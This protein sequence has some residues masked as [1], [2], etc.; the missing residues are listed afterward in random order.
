MKADIATYVS[1]CLTCAKV[2]A[3]HQKP[4]GLLVQPE[5]PEWKRDNITMDFVT[6]LPKSSQGYDTIWVIVDRLTKSAIFTP[7]RET[8]PMDK[9]AR[10]YL[11]EVVMRHGIPVSM[12]S[13]RDPRFASNFW[14]SL[15]NDLE[16]DLM[17]K[18]ARMY[19]KEVVTRHEIPV[20]IIYDRDPRFASNFWRSLQKALDTSLDMSTTYHPRTDGQSERTIQTLEDMLC[21]CVID[22]G[23]GWVNHFL[24][25]LKFSPWK[26]VVRFGKRGKLNP[27]YV[28]PFKPEWS[29]FVTIVKQQHKLDEVSYHKLFDILKQYQN[30]VNELRVERLARNANPLALVATA[31]ANKDPY[32][33]TSRSHKSYAPSSKPSIPTRSHMTTRHKGKEIAKPV[34]PPSEI[35][36]EKD[37]DPEQA[38]WD[39]DMQK[40]LALIAK[41]LKRVNDSVYHKEKMLLCKQ[42]EQGVPLQA[43]QYDWLADTNE[44]VDEHELEAHYS[45]MAKIQEVPTTDSGTVSEPVE[46]VQNDAGYNV[47]ANELQHYEQSEAVSNTCLVEIDNSNVIPDSPDMCEDDIQNDQNDNLSNQTESVSKE[48]HSK[49][50]KCFP[51]VEK[52]SISLEIV[53]QKRKEQVKDDTVWNEKASNV[54]RK[55]REQYIE[56]QDLKAQLQDKNIAIS[57]L[58]KLSEKVDSNHFACVTK[59]LNDVNARTKKPTVVPISTRKPKAHANKSIAKHHKKKVASK[60]TSQKPQSYFRMLYE[61]T[62]MIVQLILFIVDSGFTKHMAGNLKL[63]CHLVEKFLGLNHNIFSV[64][65]FCDVDLE[66]AFRKSTCF[67]RDLQGNELLTGNRGSNLYTISLQESTSSTPLCLMAKASLTQAW[68]WHRRLSYLNIHYI[69]LLSKKDIMI[70]LPKL[71]YVKDQL[72]SSCKLSKAKRSTFKSKAVPSS[73]ERIN[74]LHMDLCG[75]MQVASINGKKYIL[76]IVD[77]YLR[78]TWTLFLCSKDEAPK[79]LKDFLMM[80]QRNLQALVITIRTDRGTEFLNKTLNEFFKEKGIKHQ[81]STAQTPKQNGVVKRHAD[82]PSQQELDLLFGPLYDEFFNTGS[83]PQGKLPSMNIQPTSEPSTPTY[84]HAKENNNDQVEEGEQLQD[85]EFTNPF[86]TPEAMA[87][88]AWI[89]AMQEELHQ[90]DRV[91]AKYTL[92]IL[93]KHGMEKGQSIDTPMAM[94]PKLDAD[95]SGN[96]VDQTDY[97]SKIG[98]LMYLTSS[99]PDI[100]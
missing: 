15:Q 54:F 39:K 93:H 98:S 25:M 74:F 79:V 87:D 80:I 40:N 34:T 21:T 91:Q 65:Q 32:Y 70:G 10:I 56:I 44:E 8:D 90:F 47:F 83:N 35:A 58:R 26:G 51:K 82:V 86:C 85:D 68:L 5:I 48:V 62:S 69:N 50:L 22:F 60:S 37:S 89:E 2:K 31:Q 99:R 43:E 78:Y 49:L 95:L 57:E 7:I 46:Q 88:S 81:T 38:Q 63:L 73:N 52:H 6:K 19:L 92:E 11:K 94:K 77:D 28:G 29:R 75:P 72:C 66:V 67:V 55:E 97:H 3:E 33:Q 76:V 84:V 24:V 17:E 53:L 23:K 59:M 30:E 9:L 100:V 71:K 96:P 41:K 64:G 27:R 42:A 36:S 61:N 4:S 45:Y 13:D 12:I 16:T 1:K 18:L 14:R 20:S